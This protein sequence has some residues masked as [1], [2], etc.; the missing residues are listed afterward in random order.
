MGE[1]ND[2]I[3]MKSPWCLLYVIATDA[4]GNKE[5]HILSCYLRDQAGH[6]YMIE[7]AA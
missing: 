7:S 4:D 2:F 1:M 6:Y 3:D 5:S